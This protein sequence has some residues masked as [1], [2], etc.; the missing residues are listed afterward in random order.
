MGSDDLIERELTR[1]VIGAF[2]T[3]YNALGFGFLERLYASALERELRVR[4]H[5][6]GREVA[7]NVRY[8]GDVLGQQRLDMVVDGKLVVE[9]KST[10]LLHPSAR[11]QLLNYLRSTSLEVGLLLHF[12]PQPKFVRVIH[13]ADRKK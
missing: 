4:G 10:E 13:T 11:R 8:E 9:V 2:Y 12:G 1:S 6:V 3:V 7:V 5:W